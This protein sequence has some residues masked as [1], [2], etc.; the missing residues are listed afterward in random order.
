M[1]KDFFIKIS[2]KLILGNSFNSNKILTVNF[3]L[4]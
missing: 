1:K 2:K 3:I 4:L